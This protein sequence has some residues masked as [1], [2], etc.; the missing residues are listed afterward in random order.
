MNIKSILLNIEKLFHFFGT[1][2]PKV[3]ALKGEKDVRYIEE[4]CNRTS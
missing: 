4:E 1:I 2:K 3:F